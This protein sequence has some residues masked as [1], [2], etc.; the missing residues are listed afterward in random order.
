M[1]KFWFL[2]NIFWGYSIN[3]TVD[4]DSGW[5]RNPFINHSYEFFGTYEEFLAGLKEVVEENKFSLAWGL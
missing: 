5:W 2:V 1:K 3:F 4:R